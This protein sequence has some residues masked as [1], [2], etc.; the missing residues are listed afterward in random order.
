MPIKGLKDNTIR[1][2][3]VTLNACLADAVALRMAIKQ[4]HW[5]VKGPSFIALHELFDEVAARIADHADIM[6]EQV[7][8]LSGQAMGTLEAVAKA[9]KMKP[10]PADLV[11][12]VDHVRA[13]C[14]RIADVGGRVR[15][16]ISEVSDA[17]DEDTADIF[18]AF[19][20]QLD[21]DLWF[22]ESHLG[23]APKFA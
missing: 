14:D 20:R 18:V 21:K 9:T 2:S 3:I 11:K 5:T 7:Q 15:K 19:S 8:T 4:A 13:V 17:G 22:I 23:E 6:A 10:Y 16:A 1:T 12:D